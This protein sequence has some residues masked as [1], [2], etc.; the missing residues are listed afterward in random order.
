MDIEINNTI[1]RK[2]YDIKIILNNDEYYFVAE[3]LEAKNI[4]CK[5]FCVNVHR[6]KTYWDCQ[7]K[8]KNSEKK[9]I[10]KLIKEQW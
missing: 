8:L 1:I 2:W 10:Y 4:D 9:A 5:E 6:G 7:K 3:T